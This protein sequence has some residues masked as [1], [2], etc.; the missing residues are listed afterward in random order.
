MTSITVTDLS[1]GNGKENLEGHLK[2]DDFF[3][4]EAYPKAN[5]TMTEVSGTNGKY[6][7]KGNMTIKGETNPVAFEM[8]V[9]DHTATASFKIDRT[10]YGIKYKSG[11]FFDNLKDKAIYDEFD[12]NVMLKF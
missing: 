4:I 9:S 7:V 1:A 10:K 8:A 5:F 12:L 6:Q 11:S 3:G 2:S